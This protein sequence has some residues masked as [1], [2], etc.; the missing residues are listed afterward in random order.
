MEFLYK[1]Y[2]DI[3]MN[4]FHA[5]QYSAVKYR[6]NLESYNFHTWL[7]EILG[8]KAY[9]VPKYGGPKL[10]K[11][12]DEPYNRP[13]QSIVNSDES[14]FWM[15][16]EFGYG[17]YSAGHLDLTKGAKSFGTLGQEDTPQLSSYYSESDTFG[18]YGAWNQDFFS[19]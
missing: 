10:A 4:P 7:Y 9:P 11:S 17:S 13:D 18:I 2:A 1:H 12:R 15:L 16:P 3:I 8:G 5:I 19:S 6:R 14:E